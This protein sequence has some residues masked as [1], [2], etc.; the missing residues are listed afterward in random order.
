VDERLVGGALSEYTYYIGV[1]DF[2]SFMG[3]PPD[4]VLETLPTVLGAPFEVLGAHRV[5]VGA[6]EVLNEGLPEVRPVMDGVAR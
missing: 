1:G 6:L 2:V 3:E 5:F 4:V